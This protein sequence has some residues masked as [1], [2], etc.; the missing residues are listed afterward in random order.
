MTATTNLNI[1]HLADG[2]TNKYVRVNEGFDALDAAITETLTVDLTSAS[3]T[4]TAAAVREAVVIYVENCNT[5]GR[6]VTLP[7]VKRP[8]I[9]TADSGNSNTF[10][11]VRG[12]TSINFAPDV[13]RIVYVDGT[14]DGLRILAASGVA[15]PGAGDL[16]STNNLSDVANAATA[17]TNLDVDKVTFG[18]PVTGKP[19]DGEVLFEVIPRW[20]MSIAASLSGW[21]VTSHASIANATGSTVYDVQ[22]NG[23]SIGTITIGAGTNT[24]TLAGAG[25]SFNGSTDALRVVAP[26]TADATHAN[27]TIHGYA[28]RT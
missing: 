9:V 20:G 28:V 23:S 13:S 6:T 21:S 3:A 4:P 14:T 17:R 16:I 7:T 8:L 1:T 18:I 10:A 11:L 12:S 27:F 2:E 22:K 19:E 26:G 5:G 24:A 25:G 15:A